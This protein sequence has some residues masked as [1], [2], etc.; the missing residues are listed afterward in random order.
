MGVYNNTYVKNKFADIVPDYIYKNSIVSTNF[1]F[2]YMNNLLTSSAGGYHVFKLTPGSHSNNYEEQFINANYIQAD[3]RYDFEFDIYIENLNQNKFRGFM[4]YQNYYDTTILQEYNTNAD[5][6]HGWCN[7]NQLESSLVDDNHQP[8]LI[9]YHVKCY[10]TMLY[11]SLHDS[12]Q[13]QVTGNTTL[14]QVRQF[15]D[16]LVS[17]TQLGCWSQNNCNLS[18]N[19]WISAPYNIYYLSNESRLW[20]NGER[21][22]NTDDI[23]FA[24]SNT[25][26]TEHCDASGETDNIDYSWIDDMLNEQIFDDY[27]FGAFLNSLKKLYN[28]TFN[29]SLNQCYKVNIPILGTN[30]E[31]PCGSTFWYRQ[32][33]SS[34]RQIYELTFS[35]IIFLNVGLA[36]YRKILEIFNP[37]YLDISAEVVNL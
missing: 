25:C 5:T 18:L 7:A 10:D 2:L 21:V 33:I 11:D 16:S 35:A 19:M 32:D 37:D 26:T 9:F 28:R 15:K 31:L 29:N 20:L 3:A 13:L 27:G 4:L 34:F 24:T 12:N 6:E 23:N 17:S 14:D 30:I 22:T 8:R 1:Y 36:F